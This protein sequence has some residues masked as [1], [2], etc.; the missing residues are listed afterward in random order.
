[1]KKELFFNDITI[2][3]EEKA[4]ADK[5][6]FFK[7]V[8]K[9]LEIKEL[10]LSLERD[11][12]LTYAEIAS[13]YRYEK[14]IRNVLFRFISFIEEFY[15]AAI[16]DNFSMLSPKALESLKKCK[17]KIGDMES[18]DFECL[19]FRKLLELIKGLPNKLREKYVFGSTERIAANFT[20]IS[21]LRNAVMHNKF[22]L[23]TRLGKCY[24][25]DI[26]SSN[27]QAN[28]KNL[29][30]YLPSSVKKKCT[31]EINLCHKPPKNESDFRWALAAQL[32]IVL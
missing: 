21:E 23:L 4:S 28:V 24:I 13:T 2:S 18:I 5:Y 3:K 31:D 17:N 12:Q 30:N 20:A 9:H 27:L 1:M 7:G 14:L 16:Q 8:A 15:R 29:I 10:L 6:L 11:D 19:D 26:P 32:L 22:L 25:K